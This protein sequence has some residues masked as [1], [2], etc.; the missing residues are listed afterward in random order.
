MDRRTRRALRTQA[1]QIANV[2]AGERRN[3]ADGFLIIPGKGAPST[4]ARRTDDGVKRAP[5]MYAHNPTTG[6]VAR[7]YALPR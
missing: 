4:L 7:S 2:A 3:G 1:Y 5:F 6:G